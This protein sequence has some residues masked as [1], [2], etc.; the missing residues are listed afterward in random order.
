MRNLTKQ[1]TANTF[2]PDFD[3]HK[4]QTCMYTYTAI[5]SVLP[6]SLSLSMYIYI[7]TSYLCLYIS[8][9]VVLVVF[10]VLQVYS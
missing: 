7:Y 5:V 2:V 4:S 9:L 8:K 6:L 3:Y 1:I 10:S